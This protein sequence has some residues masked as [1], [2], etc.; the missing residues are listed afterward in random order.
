MSFANFNYTRQSH[1]RLLRLSQSAGVPLIRVSLLKQ[2][3]L[4]TALVNSASWTLVLISLQI[5]QIGSS[6]RLPVSQR[7]LTEYVFVE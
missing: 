2:T 1:R 4:Y 5:I 6:A 7:V 3:R